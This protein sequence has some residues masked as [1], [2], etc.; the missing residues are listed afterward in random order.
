M[1]HR[2]FGRNLVER[3]ILIDAASPFHKPR[4]YG[5][6]PSMTARAALGGHFSARNF[7]ALSRGCFCS[8]K[9]TKFMTLLLA[10]QQIVHVR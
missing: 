7:R 4:S 10:A 3:H 5:A 1:L 9:K 2:L 6:L 8:S